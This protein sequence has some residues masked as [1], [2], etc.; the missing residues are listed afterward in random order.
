MSLIGYLYVRE[1]DSIRHPIYKTDA[2]Y[3]I[4]YR[5][6]C[7]AQL[8]SISFNLP[9]KYKNNTDIHIVLSKASE[10]VNYEKEIADIN[11]PR[12]IYINDEKIKNYNYI[13]TNIFNRF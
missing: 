5:A 7:G 2:G 8:K 4:E 13:P 3:F 12:Y 10:Y 1:V 6:H 9:D 11:F